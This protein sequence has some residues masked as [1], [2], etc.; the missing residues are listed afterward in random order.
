MENI[1][2][3]TEILCEYHYINQPVKFSVWN[4]VARAK[5]LRCSNTFGS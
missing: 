2:R 3:A 1:I 4:Y 5:Y